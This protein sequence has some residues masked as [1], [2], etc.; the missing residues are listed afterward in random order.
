M[1]QSTPL[2]QLVVVV[3]LLSWMELP[4]SGATLDRA[5]CVAEQ[6]NCQIVQFA[7]L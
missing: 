4:H 7:C 3:V 5:A 2:H 1:L 6:K